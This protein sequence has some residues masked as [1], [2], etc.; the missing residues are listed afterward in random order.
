MPALSRQSSLPAHAKGPELQPHVQLLG[1]LQ[2]K[3]A[4]GLTDNR[5]VSRRSTPPPPPHSGSLR[6]RSKV[7]WPVTMGGPNP[8]PWDTIGNALL[9]VR[10][11]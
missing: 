4:S 8:G 10:L 7:L 3:L 11:M 1:K 9:R 2:S 6:E 5:S